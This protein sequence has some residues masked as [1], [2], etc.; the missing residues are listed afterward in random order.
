MFALSGGVVGK[1]PDCVPLH[2]IALPQLE[3]WRPIAR[4][5]KVRFTNI[6]EV[7]FI[8]LVLDRVLREWL[9]STLDRQ[10][11]FRKPDRGLAL[12]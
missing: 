8:G 4:F 2:Q 6:S 11:L 1:A 5:K 7:F 3:L 9:I 10:M 12:R